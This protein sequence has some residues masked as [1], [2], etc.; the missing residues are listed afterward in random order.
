MDTVHGDL[1]GLNGLVSHEGTIKLIDFG[2]SRLSSNSTLQFTGSQPASTFSTR[3]TAPELLLDAGPYSIEADVYA[4]GMTMLE[5]F[6]GKLPFCEIEKDPAVIMRVVIQKR[7]P[8][9]PFDSIPT[10]SR[11]ANAVWEL[12]PR[13]W[14]YDP[15]D[16]PSAFQVQTQIERIARERLHDATLPDSFGQLRAESPDQALAEHSE[17]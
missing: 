4:L 16:R 8:E 7:H 3:W 6:S 11:L 1:K 5:A 17:Q 9:R 14:S 10:P 2:N 15:L 13:C 12:L